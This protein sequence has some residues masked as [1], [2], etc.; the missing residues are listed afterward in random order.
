MVG[1]DG[2]GGPVSYLAW[3][4]R[5]LLRAYLLHTQFL[6]CCNFVCLARCSWTH[7]RRE[8]CPPPRAVTGPPEPLLAHLDRHRRL[9]TAESPLY[10]HVDSRCKSPLKTGL[11]AA[12]RTAP[13][14]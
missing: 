13:H 2:V 10:A 7:A 9:H 6:S 5:V 3:A 1:F 12:S 8:G 4:S 14:I 11:S